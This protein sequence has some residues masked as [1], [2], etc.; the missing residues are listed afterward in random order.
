MLVHTPENRRRPDP[1][2]NSRVDVFL[3]EKHLCHELVV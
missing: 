2:P 3:L 1:G